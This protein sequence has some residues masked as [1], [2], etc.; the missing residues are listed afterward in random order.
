MNE[1][2]ARISI[3]QGVAVA[4]AFLLVSMLL[5]FV[6]DYLGNH[7]VGLAVSL[8]CAAIGVA[9]LGSELDKVTGTREGLGSGN[10]GFGLVLVGAWAELLY[11]FPIWWVNA[12]T[13]P[14]LLL[15]LYMTAVGMFQFAQSLYRAAF[16]PIPETSG[17][18]LSDATPTQSP[19][20]STGATLRAIAVGTGWAIGVVA[21][22]LQVFQILKL[23]K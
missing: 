13:L 4:L 19:M 10:L 7:N 12:L 8:V 9:G 5:H 1:Q 22:T 6:P 16:A 3:K 20:R 11:Y 23:I 2:K 15:G 14:I 21:A 18:S 17:A